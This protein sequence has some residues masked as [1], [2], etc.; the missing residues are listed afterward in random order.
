MSVDG[1]DAAI[2]EYMVSDGI[3][4]SSVLGPCRAFEMF[5]AS[6]RVRSMMCYTVVSFS[7]IWIEKHIHLR[8]WVHGRSLLFG[9]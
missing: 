5:K 2:G 1:L 8:Q 4:S 3:A 7:H 9:F 6:G